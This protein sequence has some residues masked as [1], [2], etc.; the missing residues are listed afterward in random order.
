MIS[1]GAFFGSEFNQNGDLA[2]LELIARAAGPF[3]VPLE[4][5]PDAQDPRVL[6]E[7]D[8]L[9]VGDA[10]RAHQRFRSNEFIKLADLIASRESSGKFTLLV[11]SSYEK[12][13]HAVFGLEGDRMIE[14]VSS[15]GSVMRDGDIYWGY[16]NTEVDLPKV[17]VSGRTIGTQF[18]GPFLARN[19]WLLRRI[20]EQLNVQ[21]D[22]EFIDR[23]ESLM[24]SSVNF[25]EATKAKFD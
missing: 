7:L 20:L 9:I 12:L 1:V 21:F 25:A 5:V 3:G 24:L 15:F 23:L 6:A 14:R 10:S 22:V 2:H 18:F 16:L 13:A 11:G 19:P 8:L 4:L 17:N